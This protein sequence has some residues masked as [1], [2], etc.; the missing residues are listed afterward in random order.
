MKTSELPVANPTA[1]LPGDR[2]ARRTPRARRGGPECGGSA[3]GFS[4]ELRA[5]VTLFER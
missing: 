4:Q 3:L 5:I 1:S 2:S